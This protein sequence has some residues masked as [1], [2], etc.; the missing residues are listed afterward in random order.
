MTGNF[1]TD[2]PLETELREEWLDAI[3]RAT[4]FDPRQLVAQD[5]DRSRRASR[6]IERGGRSGRPGAAPPRAGLLAPPGR[7]SRARPG[8]GTPTPASRIATAA[9]RG[10]P[11]ATGLRERAGSLAGHP[12]TAPTAPQPSPSTGGAT[13]AAPAEGHATATCAGALAT[14]RGT[15]IPAGR[16]L[17]TAGACRSLRPGPSATGAT[18]RAAAEA[19]GRLGTGGRGPAARL[20]PGPGP[21]E[22]GGAADHGEDDGPDDG[23]GAPDRGGG[24]V[25]LVPRPGA[26]GRSAAAAREA[27][28]QEGSRSVPRRPLP[29]LGA[30]VRRRSRLSRRSRAPR[31]RARPRQI[32]TG[33]SRTRGAGGGGAP[34]PGRAAPRTAGGG[35]GSGMT[36]TTETLGPDGTA[37]AAG[38]GRVAAARTA[39]T[40]VGDPSRLTARP[41]SGGLSIGRSGSR[42][43]SPTRPTRP[44]RSS[45]APAPGRGGCAAPS[46]PTRRSARLSPR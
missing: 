44:T 24:R 2:G 22:D 7:A 20:L 10:P 12:A 14:A 28:G 41:L 31:A 15:R 29:R 26:D 34:T 25:A 8:S 3:R 39:P 45:A 9:A 21:L 23:D 36:A 33:R 5:F 13:E 19:A 38:L 35:T 32:P 40:G 1:G 43:S 17:T 11:H 42:S 6:A 27:S 16:M 18:T 4:G 30:A 37:A 46:S